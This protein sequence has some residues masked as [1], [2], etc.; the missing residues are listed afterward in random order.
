MARREEALD[1]TVRD[2]ATDFLVGGGEMGALMR[3]MDWA[4]TPLGPAGT[5][6]ASLCTSVSTCLNCAFP[7][8]IWWGPQLVMLY[9]DEYRVLLGS[10]KHPGA[11]GSPGAEVWAEIWDV[12]GPMLRQ[13]TDEREPARARDLL[14]LMDRYGYLEETYFSFS[15]S[16][17]ID[18][19]GAVGGPVLDRKSVV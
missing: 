11:M 18:E 16:P 8:L 6:P 2:A 15:Y 13:V 17:I 10:Q 19:K 3:T 14:L 9:N 1:L 7:I 12:I 4:N 5:W